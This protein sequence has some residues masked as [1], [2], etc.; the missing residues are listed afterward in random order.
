MFHNITNCICC[1]VPLLAYFGNL[2]CHRI[3]LNRMC[4][5]YFPPRATASPLHLVVTTA[6][7][8]MKS[9]WWVILSSSACFWIRQF[10]CICWWNSPSPEHCFEMILFF[11]HLQAMPAGDEGGVN[12][13]QTKHMVVATSHLNTFLTQIRCVC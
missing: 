13:H 12:K 2:W 10:N 4:F 1:L 3:L 6:E 8:T 7:S 5:K 9:S 11:Y